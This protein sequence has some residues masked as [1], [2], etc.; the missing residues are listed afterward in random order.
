M[1][2]KKDLRYDFSMMYHQLSGK[3]KCMLNSSMKMEK[4]S[5]ALN[6]YSFG[7]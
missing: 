1:G 5:E 2:I 7:K 6:H 4:I 3:L